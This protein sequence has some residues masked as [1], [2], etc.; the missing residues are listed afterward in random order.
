MKFFDKKNLRQAQRSARVRRRYT[1]QSPVKSTNLGM[2]KKNPNE[3]W[4]T[5]QHKSLLFAYAS[6]IVPEKLTSDN[7][8]NSY[9]IASTK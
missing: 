5:S 3:I 8:F 6:Y 2:K 4:F 1:R 7:T 9:L